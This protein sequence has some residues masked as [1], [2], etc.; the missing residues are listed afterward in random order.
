VVVLAVLAAGVPA[1]S[2]SP[3]ELQRA[4]RRANAAAA[5][6]ARAETR[7]SNVQ[8]RL[9][10]LEAQR[11]ETVGRLRSLQSAVR[12]VA[13]SAY[14]RGRIARLPADFD[15]TDL[16]ASAR[17]DTLAAIVA[18]GSNDAVDAYRAAAEDLDVEEAKL[19][20]TRKA[21][22]DALS[23]YRS[24]VRAATSELGRLKKLEADRIAREKAQRAAAGAGRTARRGAGVVLGSGAWICPV[25]GPRAFSDDF[26]D[27]RG[28]GRRRHEGN[29]ILSPRGTPVVAPVAGSVKHHE[30]GLGGHSFYLEGS[31][32][33]EYYGAH[34]DGYTDN[35][36]SV[37]A[38][39]VVGYVGNS[40]DAR[41]GPT[42]LHFE[43]HP[44]GGGA[45][46]PYPTLRAY[47]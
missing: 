15:V 6:V 12:D 38:G 18:A 34:L 43:M 37:P 41:G 45:V 25:Q 32:G 21:S 11:Q 2:A 23:A 42:H 19:A 46:N 30:N 31:D 8:S 7:L 44:G 20:S 22:A 28:G 16:S 3:A 5:D 35:V 27:P 39:T 33:I 4:Q 9:G 10:D 47:C 1:A 29:D 24:R 13:V 40:G 26:G 36:G 17:A 14:I